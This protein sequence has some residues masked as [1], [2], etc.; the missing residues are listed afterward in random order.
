MYP[1]DDELAL[2]LP[3][4]AI[5]APRLFAL[6]DAD[7]AGLGRFLPWVSALDSV[8][9]EQAFL[10]LTLAHFGQ[11]QSV[12]LVMVT[13]GVP[14]GMISFNRFTEEDRGT[15]IGY[16][17]GAAYRGRGLVHRAVG[18]M[19]TL[20]FTEYGRSRVVIQAAADNAAS[21]AVAKRAGFHLDG[22]R[23]AGIQLAD[24]AHDLNDWSL[25]RAEWQAR[26]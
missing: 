8:A 12:D 20:A 18:A 26:H 13:G 4:P 23:R 6:I 14:V 19:C 21:N 1:V 10:T 22:C 7:R 5:D 9:A 16:W 24:G 11:G 15:D 2:V 3:R 17:L 25:L